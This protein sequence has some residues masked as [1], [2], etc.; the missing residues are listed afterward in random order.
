LKHRKINMQTQTELT[1][2]IEQRYLTFIAMLST[3]FGLFLI[4]DSIYT[5]IESISPG[6]TWLK[7]IV[8][9]FVLILF[10]TMGISLFKTLKFQGEVSRKTLWYGKFIDEYISYVNMK[11]YQY[12]WNIMSIL[13]PILLILA[14]LNE[15][16]EYLPEFLNSIPILEFIKLNLAILM[17]TYGLP[18]LY[19]LRKEQD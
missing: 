5:L 10:I 2:A 18:I 11:G 14:S 15:R 9:A 16:G 17:L 7:I 6:S 3:I 13:M 1:P 4:S 12:S 19:M 8:G